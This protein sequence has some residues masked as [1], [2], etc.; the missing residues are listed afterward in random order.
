M[1]FE[2]VSRL[3]RQVHCPQVFLSGVASF[4]FSEVTLIFTHCSFDLKVCVCFCLCM[5]MHVYVPV[6]TDIVCA[7][8][9]YIYM[10]IEI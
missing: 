1:N 8:I 7:H 9:L 4:Q 10:Q 5:R 6:N 3:L 2:R